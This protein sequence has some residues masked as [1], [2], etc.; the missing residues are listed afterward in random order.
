MRPNTCRFISGIPAKGLP[1]V[2]SGRNVYR[3][4]ISS[5][6]REHRNDAVRDDV[7]RPCLD[8]ARFKRSSRRRIPRVTVAKRLEN[9]RDA[10]W[11]FKAI[12]ARHNN[13]SSA[14]PVIVT[15]LTR[16]PDLFLPTYV[17]LLSP[18]SRFHLRRIV[19]TYRLPATR[20]PRGDRYSPSRRTD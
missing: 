6:R 17:C 4:R 11:W 18:I 7:E 8:G 9:E 3:F 5:L 13:V 16:L 15:T 20:V 10:L 14:L 19:A 1:R 2:R 12:K